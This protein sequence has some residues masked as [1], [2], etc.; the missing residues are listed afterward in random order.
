MPIGHHEPYD[1]GKGSDREHRTIGVFA[2]R[3]DCA[4]AP[5]GAGDAKVDASEED[6]SEDQKKHS[7]SP[8]RFT[9]H[10]Q[11]ARQSEGDAQSELNF[12][13][14]I[15]PARKPIARRPPTINDTTTTPRRE[16]RVLLLC[17]RPRLEERFRGCRRHSPGETKHVPVYYRLVSQGGVNARQSSKSAASRHK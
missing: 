11:D 2:K 7:C 1:A 6:R 5:R 10:F 4:I 17:R 13:Q 14:A 12:C 15:I 9:R 8:F 16:V 3:S